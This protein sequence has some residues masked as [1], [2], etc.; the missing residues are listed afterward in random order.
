MNKESKI[1]KLFD[2]WTLGKV[3]INAFTI[4]FLSIYIY[5]KNRRNY[6]DFMEMIEESTKGNVVLTL[7][8]EEYVKLVAI[9]MTLPEDS[10]DDTP[11]TL[12]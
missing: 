5:F 7:T 6:V 8:P 10:A 12:Q 4:F 11:K 2:L 1:Y 3:M 9:L